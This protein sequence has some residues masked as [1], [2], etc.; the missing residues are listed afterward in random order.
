MPDVNVVEKI[1]NRVFKYNESQVLAFTGQGGKGKTQPAGSKVLMADG[2]WKTVENILVGDEVLSPQSDE[3]HTFAKVL[4]THSWFS[5]SN[6][7]VK[8]M[9]RKHEPLYSCSSNHSIPC[10]VLSLPR[11]RDEFGKATEKRDRLWIYRNFSAEEI[12]QFRAARRTDEVIGFSSFLIGRFRGRINCE[13]EPYCLGVFLG[14]G[15]FSSITSMKKNPRHE[16][17]KHQKEYYS[18]TNRMVSITTASQEVMAEVSKFYAVMNIYEKKGN[19]TKAYHFKISSE[20]PQLLMKYGLEGK[21]SGDKFIPQAALLSDSNYR[22]RLLAGMVD[23]DGYYDKNSLSLSICTK[24]KQ[25]ANDILFLVYSLGGRGSIR[26][27]VKRIK[28]INF[29]GEYYDVK[30]YLRDLDLP[31]Q[32]KR[33]KRGN[34]RFS[35]LNSNRV[36]IEVVPDKPAQVYGFTLDSPS[37]WYITDNFMVTH[38]SFSAGEFCTEYFPNFDVDKHMSMADGIRLLEI[39][40]NP[41]EDG[42]A[43]MCDEFQMVAPASAWYEM[44]NRLINLFIQT[45]RTKKA[46]FVITLPNLKLLDKSCRFLVNHCFRCRY[47]DLE[48]KQVITQWR[49]IEYDDFDDRRP[50]TRKPTI[51]SEG[52]VYEIPEVA[53]NYPPQKFVEKYEPINLAWRKKLWGETKKDLELIGEDQ[54]FSMSNI[55]EKISADPETFIKFNQK[56][57]RNEFDLYKISGAFRLSYSGARKIAAQLEDKLEG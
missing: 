4:E 26:K 34:E 33:K 6:F 19:S 56:T 42:A 20:L 49:E 5:E 47:K 27:M 57:A 45:F 25:M 55:M 52:S 14:D 23:T 53:F 18:T 24:S 48:K 12:S 30:F 15:C 41:V 31:L 7:L 39:F 40:E 37:G 51:Y 38:N 10:L 21:K 43:I 46:V 54:R 13:I 17:M 9:N 8:Q 29:E 36:A 2:T 32:L 50:W 3:T 22:K 44:S 1:R 35:Y 11:Q 16:L 28:S